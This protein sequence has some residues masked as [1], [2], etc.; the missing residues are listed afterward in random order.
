MHRDPGRGARHQHTGAGAWFAALGAIHLVDISL[1][2]C[3]AL[4][5]SA[6]TDTCTDGGSGCCAKSI[7]VRQRGAGHDAVPDTACGY[8]PDARTDTFAGAR[9]NTCRDASAAALQYPCPDTIRAIALTAKRLHRTSKKA[10]QC[11]AF[12]LG[13]RLKSGPQPP[14]AVLPVRKRE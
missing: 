4:G 1:T 3:N 9:A 7:A 12:S 13:L 11:S 10:L 5:S 8:C 2:T 6:F 14:W